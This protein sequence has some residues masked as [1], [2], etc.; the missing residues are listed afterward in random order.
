M[1]RAP[2]CPYPVHHNLQLWPANVTL[3][4]LQLSL[5][6]TDSCKEFE[7]SLDRQ[8]DFRATFRVGL[9]TGLH[10]L[11]ETVMGRPDN[12]SEPCVRC[13]M[14]RAG[15]LGAGRRWRRACMCMLDG[16]SGPCVCG[17]AERA[18]ALGMRRRRCACAWQVSQGSKAAW[19]GVHMSAGGGRTLALTINPW[20]LV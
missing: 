19:H 5:N 2:C 1:Q 3:P 9:A 15:A 18:G 13:I 16:K 10:A 6:A 11:N 14:V 7:E 8:T 20:C 17:I 4:A 12:K